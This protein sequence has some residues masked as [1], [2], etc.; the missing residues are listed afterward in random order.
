MPCN[1]TNVALMTWFHSRN[2]GTVLQ[3]YALRYVI[4]KLGYNVNIINFVQK[5][6]PLTTSFEVTFWR[7]FNKI[8]DRL[9]RT[10]NKIYDDTLRDKSFSNFISQEFTFTHLCQTNSDF[11]RLN[12]QY[13][14][15]V[16]GS[17]QIWSPVCFNPR[18]FLDFVKNQ[19]KKIAYAPSFGVSSVPTRYIRMHMTSLI[20]SFTHLS[21][22]EKEGAQLIFNL[23]HRKANVVLD[24][25]LLLTQNDWCG[26]L[27]LKRSTF[28]V[29]G[30]YI[31]CYFV[32]DSTHYQNSLTIISNK[33][34]LPIYTIPLFIQKYNINHHLIHHVGPRE[35]I[36][37][38]KNASF[39][40]TDSFH[41]TV[42]SILYNKPFYVFKRFSD[43]NNLSQNSRLYSLLNTI[44]LANKLE[45]PLNTIFDVIDWVSVNNIIDIYRQNSLFYLKNA[46]SI[47]QNK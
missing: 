23:C 22:R 46:L 41:G 47:A 44:N 35:F 3:A 43:S 32:G 1:N 28:K 19:D 9:Q 30:P 4:M 29:K 39:I 11:Q 21:V 40:C 8:I 36:D 12:K 38:I 6:F 27:S 7:I 34:Q 16:C 33:L 25:T 17:D 24:P 37:L 10:P 20:N 45:P 26:I 18:Y 14:A 13:S 5:S 31:L 15:F 2:Y 42:F